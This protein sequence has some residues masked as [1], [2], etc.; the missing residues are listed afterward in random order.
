MRVAPLVVLV[1][2]PPGAMPITSLVM[3]QL[4]PMASDP[5]GPPSAKLVEPLVAL[6]VPPQVL[7]AAVFVFCMPPGYVSEN[8]TPVTATPVLLV[9]TNV[10][11]ERLPTSKVGAENALVIDTLPTN[12]VAAAVVPLPALVEVTLPVVLR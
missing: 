2:T 1:N 5:P 7:V 11:V 6:T 8:A 12:K 3:V 10:M 9:S 4:A